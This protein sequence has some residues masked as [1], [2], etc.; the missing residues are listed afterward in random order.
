V[1]RYPAPA[2]VRSPPVRVSRAL[3]P[4][5]DPPRPPACSQ[6]LGGSLPLHPLPQL[7]DTGD[8]AGLAALGGPIGLVP[9]GSRLQL[10][11]KRHAPGDDGYGRVD[12]QG[13]RAPRPPRSPTAQRPCASAQPPLTR[14]PA[15]ASA[16]GLAGM[17]HTL[18]EK[19]ADLSKRFKLA[20]H[21]G[22]VPLGVDALAARA[23]GY[24]GTSGGLGPLHNDMY[25]GLLS[26]SSLG[27]CSGL[28]MNGELPHRPLRPAGCGDARGCRGACS[29]CTLWPWD[30]SS[31]GVRTAGGE[32]ACERMSG[33]C[34]RPQCP[35]A[36]A[37]ASARR[38]AGRPAA[39]SAAAR[40]GPTATAAAATRGGPPQAAR[41]PTRARSRATSCETCVRRWE[42]WRCFAVWEPRLGGLCG[43]QQG[44]H[45]GPLGCAAG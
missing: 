6:G 26:M 39:A 43:A 1:A 23:L 24:P 35:W 34:V 44:G 22:D 25:V 42:G 30:A 21:A 3:L 12:M 45:K 38:S 7:P 13:V 10:P 9:H 19:T 8:I 41:V 32:R 36:A 16:S 17:V 15:H 14:A 33:V 40:P 31:C 4:S 18:Q 28:P 27:L 5:H 2:A 20:F 11:L 37:Q 29:P